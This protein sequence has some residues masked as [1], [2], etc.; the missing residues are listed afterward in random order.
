MALNRVARHL[1]CVVAL[2][3]LAGPA[4]A[5]TKLL[6][7][8]DVSGDELVFTYGGDLW[9]APAA[10][11][12]A[13]RLTAH[14]G[15]EMFGKFSPDGKQIAFTGQYD[16]DEQVY[17]VPV[18]GGVPTQLTFYPARGPFSPRGGYDNQVYGWTPDGKS[19]VFRSL[20]DADGGKVE[21]ALYTVDAAGGLPVRLPMPTSGAGDFAPDGKRL[22]YSPLFRDFRTWKRYQGGWAQDLYVYDLATAAL[23]PV[24]PS[25][26]TE[27]DPM[28]IGDRIYFVSDR[29][30]TLNLYSADTSGGGV[31]QLTKSTSW[32]V[33]WAS[34]DNRGRIVY[35]LGGELRVFDV[36]TKQ[37]KAAPITVPSDGL[38]F[39]PSRVSAEKQIESFGLSPKGERA[40][41]VARGDVFT[42]PIE[43]GA[44]RNLTN[45]STAHE[46]HARWSP[47][48]KRISYVSD[49]SGEEQVYVID[50]D[51]FGKAEQLTTQFAAQLQAPE[52]SP[53]GKRLAFSDKDGKVY[54]LT[55]ADK[56]V[57]EVADDAFGGVNDYVWSPDS[58]YLAFSMGNLN[59]NET[60]HV[61]SLADGK[62]RAITDPLWNA[63]SPAW[64]PEGQYLFYLSDREFAPVISGFEWNFATSRTTAIYALALR[65]DVR[66]PFPP[67]SDEVNSEDKAK[68][69]S[70]EIDEK[71]AQGPDD[72]DA[73]KE[74]KPAKKPEPKKPV[75]PLSIEFD[76]LAQRVAKVPVGA[77]NI[78]GLSATKGHLLFTK[79]G[80]PFYGRDSNQK[81]A[82]YVFDRK[83]REDSLLLDDVQ[84]YALS[85]DG[86]KALVRHG[87]T[88]YSLID[89]TPK[90][91]NDKEKEKKS[92][93]TKSLMVDRVPAEEWATI[94]NEVW[95]RYRDFFYVR[96]MHG[97][98][99]KAIGDRYRSLLPYV[100][101]RS[102]LNYLLGE[103]VAELSIGH[104]YIENGDF[105]NPPRAK[106]GLPGARFELDKA[107]GRFRIAKILRGQNEEEKYRSPLTE[108]GVDVKEGDYVLAIDGQE[109]KGDDNPYRLLRNKVDPVTLTVN[110]RPS[111]EGA[112]K[113]QYRPLESEEN[114]L[115]LDW[116]LGNRER[117]AKATNGR[118]AYIHVPDMG[119]PGI[120]EFIKWFYGQIRAEGLIVDVRSNGGGNVSPWIIERLDT[121]LLGTRFG[122]AS[123]YPTT[124]PQTVLYGPMVAL[125]NETSASDGDIFS[126]Y[127]RKAGL[128][129]LIGK[130]TWGGVV[131]ISGRGPLLDG[132]Q[133]FVPLNATNDE[134]GNYIIE[135]EGVTPDIEVENDPASVIAG[136]DPQ[137]ERG[138][139]EVL[140]AM[141]ASP[142]HLPKKPADPVKAPTR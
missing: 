18:S 39:R 32:D 104:A 79:S 29:D 109:L 50:Q 68:A 99:W 41:F 86:L 83:K 82:L 9:R 25:K 126:F 81:V 106:V 119:G 131:G 103:M 102:D 69:E 138:I 124:Y 13:T 130:R 80:A 54:V 112:R 48:G 49:R 137:L 45:S 22:V 5:Q 38:T 34:S 125:M 123:D 51:G 74:S 115:Y 14:P 15:L 90:G 6:R 98:D 63:Q 59:G 87:N 47:D 73:K 77:D 42:A 139:Q 133:V 141:E 95:R 56:K 1:A 53:D 19:V 61:W 58:A 27:R 52:W 107:A 26:R 35:E 132:G 3:S 93:S 140:K 84:G 114:L 24:A 97:Y 11:G 12:T 7:F 101:H 134:N 89:A 136:K 108:V 21:T 43:K 37:D 111:L 57:T 65:R 8:P 4:A 67:E 100:A 128:G 55:V 40:L 60:V 76:G 72:K 116:V 96:N 16:G 91:K 10:G 78:D 92:V 118:V 31:E 110:A 46:K 94:F 30:G 36:A 66:H 44:T 85:D 2:V 105:E 113:A 117:V 121:K 135:G 75:K 20:R 88:N 64:D 120:Y 142:R 62:T 17:V 122:Y 129:P 28:W 127:F 33:R 70:E 71:G 23:T